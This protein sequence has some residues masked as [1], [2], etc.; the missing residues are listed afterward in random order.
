MWQACH[1]K[2]TLFL[3]SPQTSVSCSLSIFSSMLFPEPWKGGHMRKMS[4]WCQLVPVLWPA[5]AVCVSCC[6]WPGFTVMSCKELRVMIPFFQGF[7]P[8][9]MI[10]LNVSFCHFGNIFKNLFQ[11]QIL[12]C[13]RLLVK[14]VF[15]KKHKKW[16]FDLNGLSAP[17]LIHCCV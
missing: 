9:Y 4:T 17:D 14:H 8:F 1:I 10:I 5:V 12:R 7:P 15:Y 11:V 6:L 13:F 3:I 16:S 2:E